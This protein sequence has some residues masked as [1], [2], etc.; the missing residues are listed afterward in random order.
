MHMYA[1]KQRV[2]ELLR[3]RSTF[4]DHKRTV[5]GVVSHMN[6]NDVIVSVKKPSARIVLFTNWRIVADDC[7]EVCHCFLLAFY[8]VIG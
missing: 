7:S 5:A 1:V 8:W 3:S 2:P 4:V 6:F